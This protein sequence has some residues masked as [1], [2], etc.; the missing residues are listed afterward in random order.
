VHAPSGGP[1]DAG[2]SWTGPAA[3]PTLPSTSSPSGSRHAPTATGVPQRTYRTDTLS[4]GYR[5]GP[6]RGGRRRRRGGEGPPRPPDR[7][8]HHRHSRGEPGRRG[9]RPPHLIPPLGRTPAGHHPRPA[10]RRHRP[11]VR[12]DRR[13]PPARLHRPHQALPEVPARRRGPQDPRR[14]HPR[15]PAVR[16]DRRPG[17]DLRDPGRPRAAAHRAV[18]GR[19]APARRNTLHP[20]QTTPVETHLAAKPRRDHAGATGSANALSRQQEPVGRH[21]PMT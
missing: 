4:T 7:R 20:H 8:R 3:P 1:A 2:V 17:P 10:H 21:L 14:P 18:P 9:L 19:R 13:P 16:A 6:A 11:R 15:L 5:L 12:E